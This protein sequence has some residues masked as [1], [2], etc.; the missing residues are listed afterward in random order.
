MKKKYSLIVCCNNFNLVLRTCLQKIY[1][2]FSE[3]IFLLLIYTS[4]CSIIFYSER[5]HASC[6]IG[7]GRNMTCQLFFRQPRTFSIKI[8]VLWSSH[9]FL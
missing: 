3:R 1:W 4:N 2:N 7:H 5:N 8:L 6:R 9:Q